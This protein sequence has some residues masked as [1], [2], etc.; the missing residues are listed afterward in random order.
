[1]DWELVSVKDVVKVLQD[2]SCD[3]LTWYSA[4][5]DLLVS[6]TQRQTST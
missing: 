4:Q 2:K 6:T 5:E 3:T 1:M